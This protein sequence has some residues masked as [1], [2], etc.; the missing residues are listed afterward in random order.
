MVVSSTSGLTVENFGL[1]REST[2]WESK[3]TEFIDAYIMLADLAESPRSTATP[4]TPEWS[5]FKITL[6][7]SLSTSPGSSNSPRLLNGYAVSPS[8]C[9]FVT[10]CVKLTLPEG[11]R[12]TDMR[13]RDMIADNYV[14]AS[15]SSSSSSSSLSDLRWLGVTNIL[16]PSARSTFKQIFQL[17]GHD[18]LARDSVEIYPAVLANAASPS[19]EYLRDLLLRDPFARGVLALLHHRA[20]DVGPA[21]VKR[22][23]FIS[24]G[25]ENHEHSGDPSPL[26][27]RLDLV[28]E[29]GRPSDGN[30]NVALTPDLP[31][32]PFTNI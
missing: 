32:T 31:K 4:S 24:Q 10:F 19:S 15:P 21:F 18:I 17:M 6:P 12:L 9:A 26:E 7:N 8:R 11:G 2:V 23:V 22:F 25:Y 29:L 20:Q 1:I 14:S 27:L 5:S 13:Y 3:D 16:N 28:V 30:G